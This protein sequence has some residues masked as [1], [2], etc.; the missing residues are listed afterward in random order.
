M[1]EL[2]ELILNEPAPEPI[3]GAD[4]LWRQVAKENRKNGMLYP[5]QELVLKNLEAKEGL[6]PIAVK[7]DNQSLESEPVDIES[8]SPDSGLTSLQPSTILDPL[9]SKPPSKGTT[10]KES[11]PK[12]EKKDKKK[13]KEKKEG[14]QSKPVV[15]VHNDPWSPSR[16]HRKSNPPT[17]ARERLARKLG[18]KMQRLG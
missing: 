16:R 10:K 3:H 7:P 13:K 8:L 9:K 17:S 2:S 11:T 4:D 15:P 6:R 18:V 5:I 1:E 12:K 14:N